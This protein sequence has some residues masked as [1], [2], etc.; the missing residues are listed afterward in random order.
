MATEKRR[1]SK[2]GGRSKSAAPAVTGRL[3]DDP[4][5]AAA[6]GEPALTGRSRGHAVD[7]GAASGKKSGNQNR[8]RT[9]RG[10]KGNTG[11]IGEDFESGRQEASTAD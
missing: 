11:K 1:S 5:Q 6:S 7:E 8:G 9:A 3:T 2:A 4:R 10:A